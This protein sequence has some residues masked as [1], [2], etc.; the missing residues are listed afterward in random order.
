MAE[1]KLNTFQINIL[2]SPQ[3]KDDFQFLLEKGVY[4]STCKDICSEVTDYTVKLTKLNDLL[5]K[6]KCATCGNKVARVMEF[7]EDQAFFKK[8]N[9]FRESVAKK[10][11]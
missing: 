11:P 1:I 5:V 10:K 8:A 6:G 4:C 7:G 3:E 9:K 2:L